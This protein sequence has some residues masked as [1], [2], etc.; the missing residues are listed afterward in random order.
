MLISIKNVSLLFIIGLW[1]ICVSENIK[2]F[3]FILSTGF[4]TIEYIF[5][6]FTHKNYLDINDFQLRECKTSYLQFYGNLYYTPL[7]II[8]NDMWNNTVISILIFP[9]NVWLLEIVMGFYILWT[10]NKRV[11]LYSDNQSYF[12][13]MIT[14]NYYYYWIFCGILFNV[15]KLYLD[16]YLGLSMF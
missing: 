6:G 4:A 15:V 16:P 3:S 10:F 9:F 2:I 7:L 13:G 5:T 12:N 14:L 1:I 8:C 11:W